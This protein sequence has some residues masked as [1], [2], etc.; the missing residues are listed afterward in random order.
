MSGVDLDRRVALLHV[1]EHRVR[2]AARQ[3]AEERY[4][5][6]NPEGLERLGEQLSKSTRRAPFTFR[7]VQQARLG[8]GRM[9]AARS[10]GLVALHGIVDQVGAPVGTAKIGTEMKLLA[11]DV[12]HG[13]GIAV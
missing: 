7:P 10:L 5:S 4:R 1:L 13:G 6:A 3:F 9:I 12:V 8:E 11:G 2:E